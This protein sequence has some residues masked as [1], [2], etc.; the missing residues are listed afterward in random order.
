MN[1]DEQC[2]QRILAAIQRSG[3]L[4]AADDLQELVTEIQQ[5]RTENS[6]LNVSEASWCS[7]ALEAQAENQQ[8][9]DALEEIATFAD[10][11]DFKAK[12]ARAA[13][14]APGGDA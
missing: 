8:L 5:L 6:R 12:I 3:R 9:R 1:A 14:A 2:R 13:L 7:Q 4:S 10:N 11:A